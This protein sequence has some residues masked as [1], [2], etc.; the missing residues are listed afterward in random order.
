LLYKIA[1]S[2]PWFDQLARILR[3]FQ[4][5]RWTVWLTYIVT[6][7]TLPDIITDFL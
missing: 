5:P 3:F 6:V 7:T 2:W 1:D 4:H